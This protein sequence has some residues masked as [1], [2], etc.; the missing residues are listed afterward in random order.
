MA[1]YYTCQDITKKLF[2]I[3]GECQ[4]QTTSGE[5]AINTLPVNKEIVYFNVECLN[6]LI[7]SKLDI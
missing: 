6:Y 1:E 3:S 5:Y 7:T 4:I 2:V